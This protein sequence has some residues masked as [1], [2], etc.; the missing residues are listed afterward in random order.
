[1][2]VSVIVPV[3]NSEL[4]IRDCIISISRQT[5]PDIEVIIVDD[6]STDA[7]GRVCDFLTLSDNRIRV[8]HQVNNGVTYSRKR[9]VDV[10]NGEWVCFVDSDDSIPNDAIETLVRY[11]EHDTDI[12]IGSVLFE[13]PWKWPFYPANYKVSSDVFL[14]K[15]LTNQ[16]HS[17]PVARLIRRSIFYDNVFSIRKKIIYGED[18]LMNVRLSQKCTNVRVVPE[19][20]Y[21]YNFNEDI[22]KY[23]VARKAT[24][25]ALFFF[26][27]RSAI[28]ESKRKGLFLYTVYYMTLSFWR[29]ITAKV[30]GLLSRFT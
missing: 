30:R 12:I 4:T 2:L 18:L 15:L 3:F 5:Y 1:M 24:Y 11:I 19:N 25:L 17:G 27:L 16:L 10:S 29:S 23:A 28:K 7:S 14:Q 22:S 13:G 9:G 21:I 6:G 26:E 20:V 8:F